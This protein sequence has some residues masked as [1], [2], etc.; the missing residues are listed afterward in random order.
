MTEQAVW[1]MLLIIFTNAGLVAEQ[2]VWT[3]V[4]LNILA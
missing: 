4:L 2:A 3:A 1:T